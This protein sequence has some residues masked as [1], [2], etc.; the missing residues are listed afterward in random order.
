MEMAE[1]E[2]A[3][4]DEA[5][6]AGET[7][8]EMAEADVAVG[9]EFLTSLQSYC[10]VPENSSVFRLGRRQSP[11]GRTR[12]DKEGPQHR[13]RGGGGEPHPARKPLAR[14]DARQAGDVGTSSQKSRLGDQE[15]IL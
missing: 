9:G 5:R 7:R 8:E 10:K 11:R 1:A 2:A 6:V 14:W 4:A 12:K 3:I 13:A 15:T